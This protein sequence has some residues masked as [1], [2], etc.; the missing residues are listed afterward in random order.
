M[1]KVSGGLR[2]IATNAN[3]RNRFFATAP[4]L[5]ALCSAY[6]TKKHYNIS[7]SE[8]RKQEARIEKLTKSIE[9]SYI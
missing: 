7:M 3:A 4:I 2:G 1:L 9:L 6:E 8:V 5:R